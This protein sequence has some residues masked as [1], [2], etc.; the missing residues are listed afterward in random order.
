MRPTKGIH[1]IVPREKVGGDSAIAFP[2]HSDGRL[3]FVIPWGQF[4]I[5]GTTDTDFSGDYDRVYAD[6]ADVDYVIAAA[7]HAFPGAPLQ[8]SDVISTY[9][10]L[11]PLVLQQGKSATKTSREH[12][13]WTTASGL[14]TIAGGKLTTYRSMAEE[15]V[16]LVA[17]RLRSEFGVAPRQ[18]CLTARISLVEANGVDP[19][20]GLS[21]DALE[22]LKDAHGPEIGRV[23]E[24]AK[25]DPRL[26]EPIVEGLPYIWAEVPYA[27]EQEMAV[28]ATDI[29]ERRLHILN[30]ARDMGSS[31]APEVAARLGDFLDWDK[32]EVDRELREYQERVALAGTFKQ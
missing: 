24:I 3:M 19:A 26:N 23:L 25:R 22:H 21:T 31:V 14:V 17:K 4:S 11:R 18:P 15:L 27:V 28:T 29:L 10:G 32:G 20:D 5:V 9:A 12:E 30:E 13:I 8:R 7:Q 16:D 1:I 2:A 6:A